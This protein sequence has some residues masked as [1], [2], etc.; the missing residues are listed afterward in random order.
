MT[1]VFVPMAGAGADVGVDGDAGTGGP[2]LAVDVLTGVGELFTGTGVEHGLLGVERFEPLSGA[3][4]G[5][6][7]PLAAERLT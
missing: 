6:V 3:R 4:V 2:A 5:E 1:A 7:A